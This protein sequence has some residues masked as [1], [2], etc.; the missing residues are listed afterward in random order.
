MP[1]SYYDDP[2]PAVDVTDAP[3]KRFAILRDRRVLKPA[4]VGLLVLGMSV[5]A[6]ER[7]I[8]NPVE[9]ERDAVEARRIALARENVAHEETLVGYAEFLA[10]KRDTENR[11]REATAAIPTQAEVASVLGSAR[12]LASANRMRLV[13]F[14][15]TGAAVAEADGLLRFKASAILRGTYSNLR[16]FFESVAQFPRLVTI[17]SF[18]ASQT[19]APDGTLDATIVLTC[20]YKTL[21]VPP[22]HPA[23]DKP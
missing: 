18:S 6:A 9:A 20:Y 5:L 21:P 3:G 23:T 12:D 15:P 13:R 2:F 14:A 16:D 19:L 1:T 7:Y 10:A 17:D 4:M 11:Y 22:P 8:V